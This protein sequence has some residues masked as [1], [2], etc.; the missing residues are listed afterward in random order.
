MGF[1]P[2]QGLVHVLPGDMKAVHQLADIYEVGRIVLEMDNQAFSWV[3]VD[4]S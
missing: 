4:N 1:Q 3:T 2:L